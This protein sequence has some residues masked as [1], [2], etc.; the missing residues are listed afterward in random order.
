MTVT[1]API[2][3]SIHSSNF[4]FVVSCCQPKMARVPSLKCTLLKTTQGEANKKTPFSLSCHLP[5]HGTLQ[6][7]IT[8]GLSASAAPPHHTQTP[9]TQG[10]SSVPSHFSHILSPLS[11]TNKPLPPRGTS[12]RFSAP[13][14]PMSSPLL[15]S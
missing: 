6:A 5:R 10:L 12:S 13:G 9:F 3:L 4:L 11:L 1:L 7:V 2:I 8:P 14:E 15:S